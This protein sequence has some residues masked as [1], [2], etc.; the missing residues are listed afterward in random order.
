MVRIGINGFGRI[1][2]QVLKAIM[3]RQAATL[4]VVAVND[5]F[6]TKTKHPSSEV[7]H[8]LRTVHRNRRRGGGPLLHQRPTR[9]ELRQPRPRGNTLGRVRRRNSR[10][11]HRPFHLGREGR[12]PS[13]GGCEKSHHHRPGK[14]RRPDRRHGRERGSLRP[15]QAP[16]HLECLVHDE[17]PGTAG[18]RHPSA[19]GVEQG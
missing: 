11:K 6:D 17:L 5:L 18:V 19:F 7:R 8:Q 15:P 2:R 13:V 16:H 1:G 3:E 4:Q 14:G 12:R 9:A 10:G